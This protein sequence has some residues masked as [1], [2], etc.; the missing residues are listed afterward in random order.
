MKRLLQTAVFVFLYFFS[1][2]LVA[3]PYPEWEQYISPNPGIWECKLK[4]N[5]LYT[6]TYGAGL[7]EY[8]LDTKETI[9]Y[10]VYNSGL[11]SNEITAVAVSADD[12]I[13]L[14]HSFF[15]ISKITKEGCEILNTSNS[16]LHNDTISSIC[17][18]HNNKIWIGT[19][20]GIDVIDGENWIHYDKS[21]SGLTDNRI[22]TI[23]VDE[24][25]NKW[26]GCLNGFAIF[27]NLEWENHTLEY[28]GYCTEIAVVDRNTAYISINSYGSGLFKY[29][30]GTWE[31][32]NWPGPLYKYIT[33]LELDGEGNLWV[34]IRNASNYGIAMYNG[35]EFTEYDFRE[36]LGYFG[37]NCRT[38]NVDQDNNKWIGVDYKG[39]V[40]F[41]NISFDHISDGLFA[42]EGGRIICIKNDNRVWFGHHNKLVEYSYGKWINSNNYSYGFHVETIRDLDIN[43]I[44]NIWIASN[45]EV[46]YF[47]DE[48]WYVYTEMNSPISADKYTWDILVDKNDYL[49]IAEKGLLKYDGNWSSYNT[50]NSGIPTDNINCLGMDSSNVLWMGGNTELI[51]YD[52]ETF[53]VFDSVVSN[54]YINDIQAI[55]VDSANTKWIGMENG[56]LNYD[57]T[58]WFLYDT[59]NS[60]LPDNRITAIEIDKT[61][62]VWVGT[63]NGIG[64]LSKEGWTVHNPTNSSLPGNHIYDIEVSENNTVWITTTYGIAKFNQNGFIRVREFQTNRN[65]GIPINCFPNPFT[66]TTNIEIVLSETVIGKVSVYNLQGKKIKTLKSGNFLMGKNV[67]SWD[68]TNELGN[69]VNRGMYYCNFI[70]GEFSRSTKLIKQ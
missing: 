61:G 2:I 7:I 62:N 44:G 42:F 12:D 14:G 11:A 40:K 21:N 24:D 37:N 64:V 22:F 49:W 65:D 67:L 54:F 4:N 30:D 46:I 13:W 25:N 70:S 68:G 48:N 66:K 58:S 10:T 69:Q 16:S 56:L 38:I 6:G 20:Q 5:I 19:Q 55:C 17:I 34:S 15:G 29:Q 8:K 18:D 36:T 63:D 53:H 52:G 41:D 50:N 43:S 28:Y 57:N 39:L 32:L 3:Q 27:D 33:D 26:I 47:N 35:Y 9:P 59:L 51:S 45:S 1:N 23:E 60:G 31:Y